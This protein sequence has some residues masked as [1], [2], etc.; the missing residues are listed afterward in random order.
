MMH[1]D[2]FSNQA[3]KYMDILNPIFKKFNSNL[4][5]FQFL[6]LLS[7]WDLNYSFE[8]LK[9]SIL[10]EDLKKKIYL[11][12]LKIIFFD[13]NEK[14]LEELIEGMIFVQ[15]YDYF[16]K[17]ILGDSEFCKKFFYPNST[18]EEFF[19][20]LIE[21]FFKNNVFSENYFNIENE[22]RF[23]KIENANFKDLPNILTDFLGISLRG[24]KIYGGR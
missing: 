15:Y 7:T 22:K 18:K 8:N 24:L 19:Y 20:S 16:D 6:N 4:N 17:L 14:N 10:F 5:N 1:R 2:V 21:N 12:F 23:L 13:Q 3:K 9:K 11:K